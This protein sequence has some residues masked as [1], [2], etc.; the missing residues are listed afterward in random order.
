MVTLLFMS[1]CNSMN[2]TQQLRPNRSRN[3]LSTQ[4]WLHTRSWTL[5]L[6]ERLA[7]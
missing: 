4:G 2:K 7:G 5:L 1:G 3:K 6:A